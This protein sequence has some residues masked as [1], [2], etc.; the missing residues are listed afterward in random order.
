[1]S[2][3]LI[4]IVSARHPER[5]VEEQLGGRLE[6]ETLISDT[7]AA[8]LAAPPDLLETAVERALD[9]VRTFFRAD[10]CALLSVSADQ[11]TVLVRL[12][13]Y[14]KGISSVPTGVN[15]APLF[16]MARQTVLLERR[17]FR[18]SRLSDLPPEGDDDRRALAGM[19]ARSALLLPVE[20]GERLGYLIA[21]QTVHEECEWP[22]VYVPRLRL[23]GGLFASALE[24][25][26]M[27]EGL[28]D[29]EERLSLA[30]DFAEAGLWTLD[31]ATGLFWATERARTLFGYSPDV[32]IDMTRFQTSVH[33]EDW[34]AVREAIERSAHAGEAVNV[35]TG[36]SARTT[37]ASG[38]SS[39]AGGPIAARPACPCT[40]WAPPSTSRS[41]GRSKGRFA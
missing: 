33:P 7:S 35:D 40:S 30:A 24:R 2:H 17:P 5:P 14:G 3:A 28:R 15:L 29:A 41:G 21:L 8:L 27:V 1:M 6:F 9:R 34:G 11:Q 38:G 39:L 12:A 25:R 4:A 20:T 36:S 32:T 19:Q 26:D 37:A 23:L 22:D 18:M 13:S 10:R 16:P 31:Y